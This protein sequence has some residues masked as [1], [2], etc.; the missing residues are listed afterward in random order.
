MTMTMSLSWPAGR[1]RCDLLTVSFP[2]WVG[3][4]TDYGDV[5]ERLCRE[6]TW[7]VGP[8]ERLGLCKQLMYDAASEYKT[9]PR[10]GER[11]E[12]RECMYWTMVAWRASRDGRVALVTKLCSSFPEM[13]DSS[14]KEF[15]STAPL[16]TNS[17]GR[18]LTRHAKSR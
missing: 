17:S 18:S 5:M 4:R 10:G 9:R 12:P 16:S 14:M 11:K 7:P 1:F 15:V 3:L 8:F 6:V 13:S 2:R